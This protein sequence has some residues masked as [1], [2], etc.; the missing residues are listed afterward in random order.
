MSSKLLLDQLVVFKIVPSAA[1]S[2][3]SSLVVLAIVVAIAVTERLPS[4]PRQ[5]VRAMSCHDAL[6]HVM[7]CLTHRHLADVCTSFLPLHQR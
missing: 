7:P 4:A 3:S 5:A 1:V 6:C 2:L